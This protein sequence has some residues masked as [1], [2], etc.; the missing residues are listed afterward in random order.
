MSCLPNIPMAMNVSNVQ[1]AQRAVD[2]ATNVESKRASLQI[3]LLK[4][5]L[6]TQR[7]QAAE[8]LKLLEGKGQVLDIR[9]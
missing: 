9:A 1:A 4:K 5:S 6:E 2:S 3:Q 8:L 7:Q